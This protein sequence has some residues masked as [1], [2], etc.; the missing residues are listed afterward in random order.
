LNWRPYD[1]LLLRSLIWC[2]KDLTTSSLASSLSLA[3]DL[4]EGHIDVTVANKVHWGAQLA[5]TTA[6]PHF[7]S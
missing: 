2:S 1:P 3:A 7:P 4:I 6:L 5:L